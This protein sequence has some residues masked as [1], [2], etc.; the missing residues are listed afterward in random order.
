MISLWVAMEMY[1]PYQSPIL[2]IILSPEVYDHWRPKLVNSL[3][4]TQ[5]K[6]FSQNY[7]QCSELKY[8]FFNAYMQLLIYVE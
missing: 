8:A 2:N 1:L 5:R 3:R 7:Y 6:T 4:M